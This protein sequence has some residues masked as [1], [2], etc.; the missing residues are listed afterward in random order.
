[1]G[2]VGCPETSARNCYYSQRNNPV[3]RSSLL[4]RGGS[5]KS[6]KNYL[7]FHTQQILYCCAKYKEIQQ[8][9]D[10]KKMFMI[11]VTG[12]DNDYSPRVSK[13]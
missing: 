11:S 3:E 9:S 10:I 8:N 1:M 6:R 12:D 7:S 4:P 5:L 13:I 2:P